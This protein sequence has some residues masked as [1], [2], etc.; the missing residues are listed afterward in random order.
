[1]KTTF[2]AS[3]LIICIFLQAQIVSSDEKNEKGKEFPGFRDITWGTNINFLSNKK[4]ILI[5]EGKNPRGK[6]TKK[7][8]IQ[9]DDLNIDGV[10][11]NTIS[12]YFI[13]NRFY[14]VQA[15]LSNN[16]PLSGESGKIYSWIAE[17]YPF[18]PKPIPSKR[19]V[20]ENSTIMGWQGAKSITF[21]INTQIYTYKVNKDLFRITLSISSTQMP[22]ST[23]EII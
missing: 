11:F 3:A 21:L 16:H 2:L 14:G 9:N 5:S 22:D 6:H 10:A 1:M 8:R 12:Y 23:G 18:K 4:L 15:E 20:Y 19:N 7:Y 13:N 17:R